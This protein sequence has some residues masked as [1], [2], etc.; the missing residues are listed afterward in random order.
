MEAYEIKALAPLSFFALF[1]CCAFLIYGH[2]FFREKQNQKEHTRLEPCQS[3]KGDEL[4]L[5]EILVDQ[6][7]QYI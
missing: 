4:L 6:F 1:K 5:S 7:S 3:Y 2:V